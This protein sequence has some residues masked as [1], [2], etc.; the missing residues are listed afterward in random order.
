LLLRF[1]VLLPLLLASVAS[2]AERPTRAA[3]QKALAQHER[4]VVRVKGTREG[5]PGVIV[6]AEGQVLTSVRHVDLEAAQ[7][8]YAGQALPATVVL[9]NAHLKVAVIAVP[10]G[11]YPAAPVRVTE[12]DPVGLWLI[13][14]V[15]GRGKQPPRPLAARA[16][17]APE[18]FIDVG[19]ALPPG[20]PLFDAQGRLVAVTVERRGHGCRAL[21]LEAV[22]RQLAQVQKP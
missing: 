16:R 4:S 5:G 15:P 11:S 7:V 8:E 6:G 1:S 18:P 2:A 14:V 17:K 3:L 13:G 12:E 19:L 21:P 9:A 10:A 22:K 20:S